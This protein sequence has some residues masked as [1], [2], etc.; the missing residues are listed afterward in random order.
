MTVS[1]L[2]LSLP[3]GRFPHRI[4]AT[5]VPGGVFVATAAVLT[6]VAPVNGTIHQVTVMPGSLP[7]RVADT[8]VPV[9]VASVSLRHVR[10]YLTAFPALLLGSALGVA[11]VRPRVR[12]IALTG[13][14][15]LGAGATVTVL[16]G[17]HC[18]SGSTARLGWAA[19]AAF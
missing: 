13:L 14:L 15:A 17:C 4:G 10:L 3:T 6:A 8:L 12:T 16:T 18:G 11:F 1:R 9:A 5:I 7:L 19:L 2:S